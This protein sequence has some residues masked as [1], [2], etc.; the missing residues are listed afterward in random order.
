MT[1]QTPSQKRKATIIARIMEDQQVTLDEAI[2]IYHQKQRSSASSGGKAGTGYG[3]AGGTL[4][5]IETGRK[6]GLARNKKQED[7]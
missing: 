7:K 4:D 1:N 2:E 5:P 3:F 6:G